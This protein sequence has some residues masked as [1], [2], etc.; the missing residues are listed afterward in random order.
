L[1]QL[2]IHAQK[3]LD[4]EQCDLGDEED[5]ARTNIGAQKKSGHLRASLEIIVGSLH[6]LNNVDDVGRMLKEKFEKANW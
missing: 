4:E 1:K 3:N 2:L 6:R 5:T